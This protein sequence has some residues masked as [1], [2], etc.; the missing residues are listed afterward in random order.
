M[1][2]CYPGTSELVKSDF[3]ITLVS[4]ALEGLKTIDDTTVKALCL[5]IICNLFSIDSA[6]LYINSK[7]SNVLDACCEFLDS[8]AAV[9]RGSISSLLLNY[10]VE[11]YS[12]NDNEAK[13]QILTMISELISTEKDIKNIT[14]LF[15]AIAN[16]I[17][18]SKENMNLAKDLDIVGFI[19]ETSGDTDVFKELKA[20]LEASLK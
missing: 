10:S 9:I 11:F 12:K 16:I 17:H 3:I 13:V 14:N 20:Y 1:I 6:R 8:E 5:R 18:I 15:V 19:K 2:S 7:R 4:F